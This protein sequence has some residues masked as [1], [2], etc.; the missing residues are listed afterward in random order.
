MMEL[1]LHFIKF[2]KLLLLFFNFCANRAQTQQQDS[3][4]LLLEPVREQWTQPEW[5]N[6]YLSTPSGFIQLCS[7][8]PLMQ[9]IVN[10]VAVFKQALT[11]CTFKK[12]KLNMS[13]TIHPL[14]CHLS[15]MLPP[16][17]KLFRVINSLS[18]PAVYQ[19][20]PTK[21]Q[22]AMKIAEAELRSDKGNQSR[23][24][25]KALFTCSSGGN[26]NDIRNWLRA[27]RDTG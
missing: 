6:E 5:Q 1:L 4:A 9:S 13:E 8:A 15:W 27:I 22:T 18:S 19:T 16:L 10:T 7:N 12:R 3:F 11:G 17:L 23:K 24:L 14:A 2:N 26:A 21:L 20:L 25:T